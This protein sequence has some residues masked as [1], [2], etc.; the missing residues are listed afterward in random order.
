MPGTIF[1]VLAP[2][3]ERWWALCLGALLC[4]LG[5]RWIIAI[6]TR[7]LE[8]DRQRLE[9]AVA[10]RS[11][12][13]AAANRRLEEMSLTD[14][15]TGLQNRRFFDLTVP[16]QAQQALRAYETSGPE[17][18]PQD[19]DL[20]LFF[21]DLDHFKNINDQHGHAIG[22]RVLVEAARR[23]NAVVR[24]VDAIV[25]WGGEEFVIVSDGNNRYRGQHLA[26][27]ILESIAGTPFDLG[28]GGEQRLTCSVGWAPYPWLVTRPDEFPL[29][30]VTVLADRGLYLAKSEGRNRA[31]GLLPPAKE[32]TSAGA[33]VDQADIRFVRDIGPMA[34]GE[35]ANVD[36]EPV[37][38]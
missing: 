31:V 11:A 6:R 34:P 33:T 26:Q 3:W 24:Q 12:E 7:S 18:P 8:K 25:R 28:E 15:L 35:S 14:P 20:L 23:L 38:Q 30:K 37:S 4:L 29:E 13:L 10:L 9:E 32:K 5:L 21:I 27:R 19:R 22:D 36:E 1:V 2:W 17:H 16:R